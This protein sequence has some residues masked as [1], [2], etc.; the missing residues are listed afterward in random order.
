METRCKKQTKFALFIGNELLELKLIV[1]K[2]LTIIIIINNLAKAL[3][4]L[5]FKI[6]LYYYGRKDWT[7]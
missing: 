5:I 6:D 7:V 2:L 4:W 3:N 1:I